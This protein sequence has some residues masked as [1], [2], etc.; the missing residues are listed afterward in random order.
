M[1]VRTFH[2]ITLDRRELGGEALARTVEADGNGIGRDA[3]YVACLGLRESVPGE[4]TKQLLIV[5]SQSVERFQGRR[6][7]L[8]ARHRHGLTFQAGKEADSPPR[9]APLI[10]RN[11]PR[12]GEKPGQR[13][14]SLWHVVDPS[15]GHRECLGDHVLGV[16]VARRP[17]ARVR[18]HA[19]M[20]GGEGRLEASLRTLGA[21]SHMSYDEWRSSL[22]PWPR[23]PSTGKLASLATLGS[24]RHSGSC[25]RSRGTA[26]PARNACWGRQPPRQRLHVVL[27]TYALRLFEHRDSEIAGLGHQGEHPFRAREQ[28]HMFVTELVAV[29]ARI[30]EAGGAVGPAPR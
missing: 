7:R 25:R 10:G 16:R 11:A 21:G 14:I 6:V 2:P 22:V 12:N 5:R 4:Q 20:M 3:Q 9:A 29:A 30:G 26:R 19:P 17:P 8:T 28:L 13:S 18:E 1:E 27:E 23:P 15:P 24:G